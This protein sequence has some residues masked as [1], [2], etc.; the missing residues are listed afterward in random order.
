[1]DNPLTALDS[2]SRDRTI[3]INSYTTVLRHPKVPYALFAD[4]WRDV[5]GPLCSRIPGLGWYVQYHFA[6]EHDA[7]LWPQ[8]EG[9]APLPGY[10]LDGAVE[11][12]FGGAADQQRFK[13]ASSLL[14]ADEQNVFEETLCYDL[15]QGSTTYVDYLADPCPNDTYPLDRVHVHFHGEAGESD[16]FHAFLSEQLAPAIAGDPA[17]I[18]LRLHLPSPYDNAHPSPPAP[19]VKHEA[20]A[21]R[22][23]LAM[24]ELVFESALARRQFFNSAAFRQA[25]RG[26]AKHARYVTPFSVSGVF[27]YVRN[28]ELTLAGR[29]GSRSAQLIYQ[30]GAINQI[31]P[32]VLELF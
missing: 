17:I 19:G 3:A 14:F 21:A 6:R 29:R 22:L 10:V 23:H 26:L 8:V 2:S 5:H 32:E 9:I 27:T 15:P 25:T 24:L 7:H 13:A 31:A 4:Y 18:K 12:G 1:M 30:L 11:I 16:A 28:G 20:P